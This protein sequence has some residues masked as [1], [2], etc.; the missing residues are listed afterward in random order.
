[1]QTKAGEGQGTQPVPFDPKL[2][3]FFTFYTEDEL[4]NMLQ[5][6]GFKV[7]ESYTYNGKKR[8]ETDRDQDWVVL[9]AQRSGKKVN[10]SYPAQLF[11]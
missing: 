1:M 11:E 8:Y 4:K 5:V 2:E 3:R 9:I 10:T 6:A 7:I